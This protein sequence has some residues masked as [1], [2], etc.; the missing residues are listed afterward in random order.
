MPTPKHTAADVAA[1]AR[2]LIAAWSDQ[3]YV[4]VWGDLRIV[5][6]VAEPPDFYLW[7]RAAKRGKRLRVVLFIDSEGTVLTFRPGKW[8]DHLAT[9]AAE[10]VIA[11]ATEIGGDDE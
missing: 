4:G 7:V 3:C 9:L 10:R 5:G 11:T 6:S 8:C 2:Q 1:C